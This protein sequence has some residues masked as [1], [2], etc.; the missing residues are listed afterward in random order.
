MGQLACPHSAPEDNVE[1][2]HLGNNLPN[3]QTERAY[4]NADSTTPAHATEDYNAESTSPANNPSSQDTGSPMQ[5]DPRT[6]AQGE[7]LL[8]VL[9]M[10]K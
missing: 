3:L 7:Q 2:A 8:E 6:K 4:C 9:Q 1:P 10:F 5:I